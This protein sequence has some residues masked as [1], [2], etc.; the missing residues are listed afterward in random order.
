[1]KSQSA[2]FAS[3]LLASLA[4]QAQLPAAQRMKMSEQ[5]LLQIIQEKQV[6][7]LDQVPALLPKSFRSNFTIKHGL[8]TD[9]KGREI[10]GPRGHLSE[11][12]IPGLGQ[13]S[14]PLALRA[15]LFDPY[16][17]FGISYN[18]GVSPT[19]RDLQTGGNSLDTITFDFGKKEFRLAKIDF[20]LQTAGK[21][22][23]NSQNCTLCHGPS[24]RPIFSMYPDW[25]RFY[26]SDNDELRFGQ[27]PRSSKDANPDFKKASA[28]DL[29][30]R[31]L[32]LREYKYFH[33]FKETV[34]PKNPRYTP[35][36]AKDA[37]DVHGFKEPN[38]T[39]SEYP[40]RSDVE[41]P[42]K[43][44]VASDVSRAFTRRAGLRFNLLYSRLFVQQVVKKITTHPNFEKFGR[45]FV[46]NTMRCAPETQNNRNVMRTWYT[47]VAAALTEVEK[48]KTIAYEKWD[49][50][51]ADPSRRLTTIGH[52][53]LPSGRLSLRE[54]ESLLD[55][56]Q[57]LALFGLKINDVDMRFTY[58]HDAYKPE[59]A[60]R[61]L[62]ATSKDKDCADQVMQVG[63]LQ[64]SYFNAYND[65]STTMDEHL[66]AELLQVLAQKD[67]VLAAFL[68]KR[69][70]LGIRGLLNKYS[71]DTFKDRLVFDREF[72][73]AMDSYSK[74]F[75]LPY[76]YKAGD[77]ENH[78][79]FFN[80][81]HRALFTSSY[82]ESYNGVCQIL[83]RR[84]TAK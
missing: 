51:N 46:Y 5:K 39:Y 58:H 74:W 33:Q 30:R 83:E 53:E 73:T 35:L 63:Y 3:L 44:L 75:S 10:H 45:F 40:Y 7:E 20:P 48:N 49:P 57:N 22:I 60:F 25:P 17:G 18:G 1:M 42:G 43:E 2:I 59:N 67:S 56:G 23:P 84:L 66:T 64:K 62:C 50:T 28:M 37:Y 8:M 38:S 6:T 11:G 15:F 32:Q 26:G 55:Y 24:N 76:P 72:F 70:A 78:N 21:A 82:R 68:K 69:G 16:T 81:H 13:H 80:L 4:A 14:E 41:Q 79:S 12:D 52:F 9:E 27:P 36:F 29:L 47:P 61:D 19:T 34:V 31:D 54:G 65:G 71:G 77:K